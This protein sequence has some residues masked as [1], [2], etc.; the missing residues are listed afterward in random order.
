MIEGLTDH[1]AKDLADRLVALT[2]QLHE[3]SGPLGR[4]QEADLD[5][6]IVGTSA[7]V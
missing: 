1:R 7:R 2:G 4:Q 3:L 5:D 6:H